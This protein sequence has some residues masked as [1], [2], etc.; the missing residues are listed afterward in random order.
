MCTRR[1]KKKGAKQNF[2]F[3]KKNITSDSSYK[4]KLHDIIYLVSSISIF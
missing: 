1:Y 3:C 4:I 2:N